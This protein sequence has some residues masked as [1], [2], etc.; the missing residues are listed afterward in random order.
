MPYKADV[1]D[2]THY[3]LATIDVPAENAEAFNG[4]LTKVKPLFRDNEWSLRLNLQADLPH[5]SSMHGARGHSHFLHVW[6]IPNFDSLIAVMYAA[7]DNEDYVD[8]EKLVVGERQNLGLGLPYDPMRTNP[9]DMPP[10]SHC[11]LLE[12]L[13]MVR[14]P[15]LLNDFLISMNYA[16]AQMKEYGWNLH[17]AMNYSTGTISRYAHLWGVPLEDRE[18]GLRAYLDPKS[19]WGK[20]HSLAISSWERSWWIPVAR[21]G[22]G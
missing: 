12:E 8:L 4:Q 20:Q 3:C 14:S 7:A 15:T 6:A 9:E 5:A 1:N 21:N 11:Y 19:D 18:E 22:G 17:C 10:K 2:T 13:Q 16:K